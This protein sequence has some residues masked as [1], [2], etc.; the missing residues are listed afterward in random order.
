[1]RA[2]FE[3]KVPQGQHLTN[4]SIQVTWKATGANANGDVTLAGTVVR[5]VS[6]KVSTNALRAQI[7]GLSPAE[8]RKRLERDVPGSKAMISISPVAVPWLPLI[9]DHISLTVLVRPAGL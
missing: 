3:A 5:F 2:A 1:M 7:R 9:A 4:D 8:A 6:P